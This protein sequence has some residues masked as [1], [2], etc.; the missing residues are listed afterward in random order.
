MV[1]AD[2]DWHGDGIMSH[3]LGVWR[4]LAGD[5]FPEALD[6]AS[7]FPLSGFRILDLELARRPLPPGFGVET[8]LNIR[9]SVEGRHVAS[10]DV[11]VFVGA[12]R[13][14]PTLSAEM[15]AAMF[16][17]AEAHGRLD[18]RMRPEWEAW[19]DAVDAAIASRPKHGGGVEA[20]R[21][22]LAAAAARPRPPQ[23]SR[24]AVGG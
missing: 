16:D 15:A 19:V 7:R 23:R 8:H 5:L 22:R 11:G 18:P 4:P 20:W 17:L 3:V 6:I 14:Q 24:A 21:A 2:F 12:I 9:A 13:R 1:V 10:V